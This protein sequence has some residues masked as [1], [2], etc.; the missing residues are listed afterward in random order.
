ME[1]LTTGSN[2]SAYKKIIDATYATEQAAG[3]AINGLV[4]AIIGDYGLHLEEEY[5]EQK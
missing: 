4:G 2:T 1:K 3:Y 5:S